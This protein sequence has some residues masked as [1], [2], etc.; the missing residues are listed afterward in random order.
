M[1]DLSNT[2]TPLPARGWTAAA[3][4]RF[5][6]ALANKGN[7]RAACARVGLSAEAAYRLRRRDALFAR[8][9]SAAIVLARDH[10]EQVLATH[11]LDGVEEPVFWHGEQVGTRQRYDTRLLLAH[12]ARLDRLTENPAAIRDAG[13]FDEVL[14]RIAGATFPEELAPEGPISDD[15]LPLPR[16]AAIARALTLAERALFYDD[17]DQDEAGALADLP[18]EEEEEEEDTYEEDADAQWPD[19]SAPDTQYPRPVSHNWADYR[20]DE[21]GDEDGAWEG[22]GNAEAILTSPSQTV[23]WEVEDVRYDAVREAAHADTTRL[24]DAWQAQAC[25]M[26]DG[27]TAEEGG[28]AAGAGRGGGAPPE[29]GLSPDPSGSPALHPLNRVNCVNLPPPLPPGQ[30]GA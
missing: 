11:A 8:G 9:W 25:A 22:S 23:Q 24:W 19:G 14:A 13:R 20:D 28:A 12:L 3:K 30:P 1:V 26:V 18:E 15:T 6:E 17:A 4:V 10:S 27:L 2:P 7:V 5:L 29:P 16:A 21:N